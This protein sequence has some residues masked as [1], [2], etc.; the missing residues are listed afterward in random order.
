MFEH[1][2]VLCLSQGDTKKHFMFFFVLRTSIYYSI[3]CASEYRMKPEQEY[4]VKEFMSKDVV[5]VT[6]ET[7]VRKAAEVMAAEHVSSAVVCENKRL[8]GIITEKDLARKIVAKGVDADK[9]LAKDIMTSELVT[10]EPEKSLYDAMLKLNKKKVTH[11]PVVKNN[12]LV[13]IISS[14]DILKVQ[15]S[16]MEILAGPKV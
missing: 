13:G 12:V 8:V 14:M 9:A 1:K 10:I 2:N 11:L 6:P 16:Y 4:K 3:N 7:S 5:S 15:P